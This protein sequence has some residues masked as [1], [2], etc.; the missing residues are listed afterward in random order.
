MQWEQV[1]SNRYVVR[2]AA[3]TLGFV[4]VVGAVFVVLAG[5]TYSHAVTFAQ[6]L[7]FDEAVA[8]LCRDD[9]T[10]DPGWLPR[11]EGPPLR[12]QRDGGGETP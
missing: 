12:R 6:T 8:A 2:R 3:Q 7:N 9:A 10:S 11:D 4:D 1:E 5:P